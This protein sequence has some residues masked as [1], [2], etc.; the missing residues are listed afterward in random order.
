MVGKLPHPDET[1]NRD[2][3]VHMFG[4]FLKFNSNTD[5]TTCHFCLEIIDQTTVPSFNTECCNQAVH[6]EC[7]ETWIH[8]SFIRARNIQSSCAYSRSNYNDDRCFLCLKKV[9]QDEEYLTS[10]SCKTNL[11][12]KCVMELHHLYIS[13]KIKP[14]LECS[15][16][17]CN[18]LWIDI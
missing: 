14:Y 16:I 4:L 12:A 6:C 2:D 8:T 15:H 1:Y 5:E 10:V 11:H 7:F 18:C 9:K 17:N 13:K 3:I